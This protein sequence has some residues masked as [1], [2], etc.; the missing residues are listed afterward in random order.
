MKIDLKKIIKAVSI[1]M[2]PTEEQKLLAEKRL[3]ICGR[4]DSKSG[5]IS[6]STV[7]C[8]SCGCFLHAKVFTDV[9]SDC[10][11]NKWNEV[12]KPHFKISE[13]K[14]LI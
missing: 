2:S 13:K 10:P 5:D 14:T 9:Y 8:N 7:R 12:D 6:K 1:K 11:E 4:C 3:E